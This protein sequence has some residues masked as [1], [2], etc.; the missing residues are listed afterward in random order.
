M[1]IIATKSSRRFS[2]TSQ[3]IGGIITLFCSLL[4]V[5]G[6]IYMI[7]AGGVSDPIEIAKGILI[8]GILIVVMCGAGYYLISRYFLWRRLPQVVAEFDGRYLYI[9]GKKETKIHVLDLKNAAVADGTHQL[10]YD[11][12]IYLK[13]KKR[14]AIPFAADPCETRGKLEK[15]VASI[16]V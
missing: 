13:S 7:T 16:K 15:I 11:V 10:R 1:E 6:F 5:V 12:F 9:H 14:L 4:F 2:P 3:L 8:F